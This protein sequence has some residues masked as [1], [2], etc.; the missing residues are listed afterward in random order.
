MVL[1]WLLCCFC[2]PEVASQLLTFFFKVCENLAKCE[3]H[4]IPK[5]KWFWMFLIVTS[6]GKQKKISTNHQISIFRFQCV[7]KNIEGWILQI[8]ISYYLPISWGMW[9]ALL[10]CIRHH[11]FAQ[12]Q[13]AECFTVFRRFYVIMPYFSTCYLSPWE[14]FASIFILKLWSKIRMNGMR[15]EN[16]LRMEQDD[17]MDLE[18]RNIKASCL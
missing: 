11:L 10:C 14:N 6:E 7:T 8:F 17:E 16:N 4:K 9:T 12:P 13:N 3:I 5:M 18:L 1:K 15:C 2:V